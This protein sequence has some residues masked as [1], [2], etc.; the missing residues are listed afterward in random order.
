MDFFGHQDA[1]RRKTGQ[2][3]VLFLLAVSAVV[4]AVYAAVRFLLFQTAAEDAVALPVFD[5]QLAGQVAFVTIS[6]I[7]VGSVYKTLALHAGGKA[8]ASMLGGTELLP[9][10]KE[11]GERRLLNVVEEMA[12]AAGVPV[13]TVFVLEEEKGI[14]AFAAGFSTSDAVIGVTRG[15]IEQLSRDELQG[16][17]AHEFSHLLNSDSRLN[18]RLIG[19][20][21]GIL[22]IAIIGRILLQGTTGG[23]RK[24][25]GLALFGLALLAIG[26][27]GVFFGRLIKAA[28]S[29]Q[30]EFL[31]DA[32][33][34]QFTRNPAGLAGALQRIATAGSQLGTARAEEASHFFFANGL[35][36]SFFSMLSTHPPIEERVRRLDPALYPSLAE[37]TSGRGPIRSQGHEADEDLALGLTGRSTEPV[38]PRLDGGR[39]SPATAAAVLVGAVGQLQQ[40]HIAYAQELRAGLPPE[41]LAAAREPLSAQAIV[42]CLLLDR[43]SKVRAHQSAALAAA[44]TELKQ[45][46]ARM[47]PLVQRCPRETHLPILDLSMPALGGMSEPQYRALRSWVDALAMADQRLELFELALQRALRRSLEQRFEGKGRTRELIHV[48]ANVAK[49][50]SVLLS[51]LAW[52]GHKGD[53]TGAQASFAVGVQE[54]MLEKI[55][56]PNALL[57]AEHCGL[58]AVDRALVELDRLIPRLKKPLLAACAATVATDRRVTVE[59]AELLRI[60]ADTLGCP[61]PPLLAGQSAA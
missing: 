25:G 2:L 37:L 21:H 15:A 24:K 58:E 26:G 50:I 16:V 53:P 12:L 56:L 27:I 60:I 5:P 1:A 28:I 7:L 45:E 33:A 51:A 8:V 18:L 59:E 54:L 36:N 29:R 38:A 40:R 22:V 17:I 11:P 14:N 13:P 41:L 23:D 9:N 43:D 20:L 42:L 57:P 31:A 34:A 35:K 4:V 3:V 39:A 30:R 47:A 55:Q 48:L 32:S 61:V 46:I 49:E 19:L 10:S 6:V 44:P 52:S